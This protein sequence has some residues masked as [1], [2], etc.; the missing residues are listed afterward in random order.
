[1]NPLL[2]GCNPGQTCD[3]KLVWDDG[4]GEV[5]HWQDYYIHG[6]NNNDGDLCIR[7][8]RKEMQDKECDRSYPFYCELTCLQAEAPDSG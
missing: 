7:N 1:M 4:T 2:V 8:N 3:S 5:F 6:M